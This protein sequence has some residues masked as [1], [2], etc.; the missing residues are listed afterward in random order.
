ML[1]AALEDGSGGYL[2]GGTVRR[3]GEHGQSLVEF[4]A[5]FPLLLIILLGIIDF[6]RVFTAMLTIEAAAREATDYGTQYP[7]YWRGDPGDPATNAG[8]TVS[9]MRNRACTAAK[10]LTD[11]V[12]PD[13]NCTNPTFA[14]TLDPPA[15]VAAAD[16]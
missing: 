15:G 13:A 9:G 6:S 8:K 16:C 3:S 4:A 1:R 14:Y 5:V 7:W 10:H 2:V 12:G 11:Y